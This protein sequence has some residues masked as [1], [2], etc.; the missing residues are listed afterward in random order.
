MAFAADCDTVCIEIEAVNVQALRDPGAQGKKVHP[1][2]DSLELIQDKTKQ[3]QF[4]ADY[5]IPTSRFEMVSGKAEF[6]AATTVGPFHLFGRLPLVAM[7]V[8]AWW[9]AAAKKMCSISQMPRA[10]SKHLWTLN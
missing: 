3:K 4:Y 9:F 2:P 7:T 1:N 8:L 6:E 5:N 10:C